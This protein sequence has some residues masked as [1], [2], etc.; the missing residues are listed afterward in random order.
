MRLFAR[1][2]R[3]ALAPG[4]VRDAGVSVQ[5]R[6]LHLDL[7][8]AADRVG[9]YMAMPAE[10]P[11]DLIVAACRVQCKML[12]IPAWQQE[13][14]GYAMAIFAEGTELTDGP[15]Q[16]AQPLHSDWIAMRELDLVIVPGVGFDSSGGRLGHGA[17][18]YDRMLSHLRPG[19]VKVG[20]CFECQ[21]QDDI[22]QC[23]TDIAMDFVVT[24]KQ[25]LESSGQT[26]RP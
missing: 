7:F 12:C 5:N 6:L 17:G 4:F 13:Q 1:R 19:C 26:G 18:H 16:I 10:V 20:F 22:P 14:G 21:L 3:G 24:E 2:R 9:V 8:S 23:E 11:C 25:V 15:M